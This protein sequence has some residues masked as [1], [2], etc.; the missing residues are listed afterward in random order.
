V[1]GLGE[2]GQQGV[3]SRVLTMMRI[4]AA[5]GP[6][7]RRA[8]ADDPAVDV[9]GQARQVE[10]VIASV[11]TSWFSRLSARRVSQAN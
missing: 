4:Q 5:E 8:G 6:S 1:A 10:G 7:D 9:D 3:V 11:T 2:M